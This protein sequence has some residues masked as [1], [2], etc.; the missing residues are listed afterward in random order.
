[1][2][3]LGGREHRGTGLADMD[4]LGPI[5]AVETLAVETAHRKA[6]VVE[7]LNQQLTTRVRRDSI[8]LIVSTHMWLLHLYTRFRVLMVNNST[9]R[10][11]VRAIYAGQLACSA[12]YRLEYISPAGPA[13]H[14]P[15]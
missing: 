3:K 9:A 13:R 2:E 5:L 12:V 15:A 4:R 1:M 6:L 10:M 14:S 7:D 8:N 11:S